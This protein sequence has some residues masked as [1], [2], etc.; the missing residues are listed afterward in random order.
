MGFARRFNQ[1]RLC[2]PK[3]KKKYF[4]VTLKSV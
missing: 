4:I 3:I 1:N 2:L